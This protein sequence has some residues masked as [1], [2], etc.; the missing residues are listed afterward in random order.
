MSWK[1]QKIGIYLFIQM[2]WNELSDDKSM[3]RET[4]RMVFQLV[5]EESGEEVESGEG[6]SEAA[7]LQKIKIF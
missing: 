4:Y 6:E 3:C 7:N 5:M 2:T 1:Q